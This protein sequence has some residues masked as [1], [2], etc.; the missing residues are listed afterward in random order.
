MNLS[1]VA[2][3]MVDGSTNRTSGV[4]L[5]TGEEISADVVLSN[6]TAKVTYL[7]LVSNSH[8][9]E[10]FTKGI[11]S[12]DY[13]SPVTKINVAVDCI[14]NFKAAPSEDGSPQPHHRCTIHLNC[15]NMDE[16]HM[17]YLDAQQGKPSEQP[18]IE[19]CIPSS[20][21]IHQICL[22]HKNL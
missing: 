20:L 2:E 16:I 15:E 14:P 8:L 19:M 6:A 7:D 9:P 10:D 18:I 4:V 12:V 3:I 21:G 1:Q 13:T 22:Y 17:A 5:S 11:S